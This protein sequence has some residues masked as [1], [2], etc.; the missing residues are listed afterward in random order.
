MGSVGYVVNY[1]IR[2]QDAKEESGWK[3]ISGDVFR[4]PPGAADLA[5][6]VRPLPYYLCGLPAVF[7]RVPVV[8][9]DGYTGA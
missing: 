8:I 3:L 4:A 9:N 2:V 7:S 5:V 6:Q 1:V